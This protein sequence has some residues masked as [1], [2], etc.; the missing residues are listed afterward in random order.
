MT[1]ERLYE[2]RLPTPGSDPFGQLFLDVIAPGVDIADTRNGFPADSPYNADLP[3][4][5]KQSAIFGEASY[6]FGQFKL[7]AGGRYYNFKEERDF[8]S[9][10]IFANGDTRIGD[11]TK[12]NGF[13]PRVIATWEPRS[14][15]QRPL[16]GGQGLPSRR[17]QR[18]LN[19]PLCS[20]GDLAVYGRSSR[21]ITM[22]TL[23]NYEAGVNSRAGR[24]PSM[25]LRFTPRSATCRSRSMPEAARRA[26]CS[27][28]TRR[29]PP[30][31]GGILPSRLPRAGI[32]AR[33]KFDRGRIRLTVDNAVLASRTG[34]RDGN[35]LPSVP[36]FQIA[37]SATY[38]S[39]FSDNADWYITGSVQHVG[40]RITQPSD[41]EP[42]NGNFGNMIFYD[43]VT[44]AFGDAGAFDFTSKLKLK[45]Y[46]LVNLSAGLE[47]DNGW[48]TVL[49]VNN[50]FDTNANLCVRSAN[51]AGGATWLPCRHTAYDRA[52]A[53]QGIAAPRRRRRPLPRAAPPP[54]LRR[55]RLA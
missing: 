44:G 1:F 13:S 16:S 41:Q 38:S 53:A 34:I 48:E 37:A 52:D 9:G 50:L 40:N 2:Q 20:A 32:F 21:P 5:I 22:T 14:K 10:G 26:S 29:I 25:Q 23:W 17:H 19:L 31:R 3:Y 33:R 51:A 4:D 28:S 12:S 35:R 45:A 27:M 24:L 15:S 6:D 42:G 8:I 54:P 46:E 49:Y 7:T 36:K 18:P 30:G 47:F 11:K 55:R 43:P 39:R